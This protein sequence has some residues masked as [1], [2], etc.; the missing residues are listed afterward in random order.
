MK[1]AISYLALLALCPAAASA[2]SRG[3]VDLR[4][5]AAYNIGGTTPMGLPAEIRKIRSYNPGAH[6]AVS[7]DAARMVSEKWGLALGAGYETVGMETG[8]SARNYHL[9]M[10]IL[11]GNATG[12]RTGYFTG[13]I[14]NTTNISYIFIPLTAVFR[15]VRDWRFDAGVYFAVAVDREFTGLVHSGQIRETPMHAAIGID[16]AEYDYSSDLSR[17]DYGLTIAASRRVFRGLGVRAGLQWGLE[18]VLRK[19][20]RKIDMNTYNVYLNVGLDY[21]F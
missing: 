7:V 5:T 4:V 8:I 2:I 21:T 17:F 10:N 13:N 3:A 18:S 12:T 11:A 16:R 1:K 20:V 15:P 14:K 19:S 6:F 9:T